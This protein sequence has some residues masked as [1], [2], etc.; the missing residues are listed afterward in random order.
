MTDLF[1]PF[2][3]AGLKLSNR[4]V[5]APMTRS[6]ASDDI[7]SEMVALY[8][9]QRATAGLIVSEGA[10]ISREGQGYLFNP[11]IFTAEQIAGW[12][13]T[14]TSVHARGGAIF[15]QIWHVGRVSHPSIQANGQAPVSATSRIARG[16]TAY[17]YGAD[18]KPGLVETTAPRQLA[19]DEVAR[20][21]AD[22]AKAAA[23]A[24]EAG[25]DGVEIH[26][27]NGYLIEQFLN[28]MVNDR[29]DCYGA[30]TMTDRL[31]F[32][33][34]TVDAVVASIGRER[35]GIRLSPFGQLFDMPLH[36]EIEAT[37]AALATALGDRRLAYV[38]IMDQSGFETIRGAVGEA[39]AHGMQNLLRVLRQAL[40]RT[41]LIL[42]GGMT[43]ERADAL[44]GEGLIDL[45]GFGKAFISNPDLVARL[46]NGWPL[47]PADP[48]TFYGGD[49]HG[50]VDY[51]PYAGA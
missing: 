5:M 49:A 4:V 30:G 25:F 28:P 32:V 35:V 24:I 34:E 6:R 51:P 42:T 46:R 19:T 21:A 18:G 20:V 7:A 23:N 8:Y 11:G 15:A 39:V 36:D 22:Y 16:A 33:L 38:H 48:T 9:A 50:Y 13:R 29:T 31:R 1:T 37:Y 12:K 17:G 27:A 14:T 47:T 26:G 40:P 10:P 3:L 44:I 43:H 2:D 45:V 41:A